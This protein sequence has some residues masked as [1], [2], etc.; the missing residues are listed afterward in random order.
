[1]N[2][3]TS[4]CYRMW[5]VISKKNHCA[6]F[7][8]K[9]HPRASDNHF[10]GNPISMKLHSQ[11]S[12]YNLKPTFFQSTIKMV[13]YQSHIIHHVLLP[14]KFL[15]LFFFS[16]IESGKFL[17]K[18]ILSNSSWTWGW[19]V[20]QSKSRKLDPKIDVLVKNTPWSL[21]NILLSFYIKTEDGKAWK[22]VD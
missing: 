7:I 21:K 13:I 5:V 1:M 12:I 15:W 19:L 11:Q 2:E 22:R 3:Y 17:W 4:D 9:N 18:Y 6:D 16:R 10:E 14:I 20:T 8:Q